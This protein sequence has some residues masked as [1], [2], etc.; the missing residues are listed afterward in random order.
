[1]KK[2]YIIIILCLVCTLPLP[3]QTIKGKVADVNGRVLQGVTIKVNDQG[4]TTTD[5]KGAFSV[6]CEPG[7]TVAV[8]SVGYESQLQTIQDCNSELSFQLVESTQML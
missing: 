7:A 8:S 1:M 2:D 4:V 5:Q 6:N 3:A